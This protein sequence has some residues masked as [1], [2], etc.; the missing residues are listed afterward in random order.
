MTGPGLEI[1]PELARQRVKALQPYAWSSYVFQRT[2]YSLSII[3]LSPVVE[4]SFQP[5]R[6]EDLAGTARI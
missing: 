2:R 6:F 5:N 3:V 4:L 1:T